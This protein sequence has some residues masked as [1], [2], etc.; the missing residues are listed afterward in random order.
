MWLLSEVAKGG[1]RGI[2]Y[3]Y[4]A[5]RLWAIAIVHL[6]LYVSEGVG[7]SVIRFNP[8]LTFH[9]MMYV[10]FFMSPMIHCSVWGSK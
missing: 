3:G 2:T 5:C 4:L 9:H 6:Y 8:F 1:A 10:V 7:R